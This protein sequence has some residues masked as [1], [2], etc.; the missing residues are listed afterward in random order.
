[1]IKKIVR[2]DNGQGLVEYILV[3]SLISILLIGA[4][5]GLGADISSLFTDIGEVIK[6]LF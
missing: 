2:E 1:M 4:L 6:N 3:I 5:M